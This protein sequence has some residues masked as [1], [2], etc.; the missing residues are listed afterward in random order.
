MMVECLYLY[1]FTCT[2]AQ[3]KYVVALYTK[4]PFISRLYKH[5]KIAHDEC[6]SFKY[7]EALV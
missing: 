5:K 6:S 2:T 1:L 3:R 4:L 7:T